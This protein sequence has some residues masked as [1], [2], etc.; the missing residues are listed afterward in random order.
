VRLRGQPSG[1]PGFW[2]AGRLSDGHADFVPRG[3]WGSTQSL[4]GAVVHD[5]REPV[6]HDFLPPTA[7]DHLILT[8]VDPSGRTFQL[9]TVPD[10]AGYVERLIR[11]S[12]AAPAQP[13]TTVPLR[14]L[15]NRMPF[16]LLLV[17]LLGFFPAAG[18]AAGLLA[19]TPIRATV[20]ANPGGDSLCLATAPDTAG[21]EVEGFVSC[22]DERP[23][24][25]VDAYLHT[26]PGTDT[27]TDLQGDLVLVV[28]AVTLFVLGLFLTGN[29]AYHRRIPD[30]AAE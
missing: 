9:A 6:A 2:R 10:E 27:L 24:E 22:G 16:A 18:L 3:W 17:T 7:S 13:A 11:R 25:Q 23:G 12:P 19:A 30:L 14:W 8:C 26:W 21:R 1:Y 15:R 28:L 29:I 20:T 4:A 5:V